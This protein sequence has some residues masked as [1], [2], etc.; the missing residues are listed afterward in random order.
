MYDLCY[1]FYSSKNDHAELDERYE[2]AAQKRSELE[3]AILR[4]ER[5]LAEK[6]KSMDVIAKEE[7]WLEKKLAV[8]DEQITMLSQR[9][10]EGW[11]DEKFEG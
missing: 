2:T 4:L 3:D 1:S 11:A 6:K 10:K 7:K 9:L 5:E 8:R